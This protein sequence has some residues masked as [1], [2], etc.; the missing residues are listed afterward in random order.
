MKKKI[1]DLLRGDIFIIC[2]FDADVSARNESERKKLEQL[3]N[4]Y[5]KN[6]NLLFCSSLPSIEYWFL[7]HYLNTNQH[8]YDAKAVETALK[9]YISDYEKTAQ[10]LEKKRW[11]NDLCAENKFESAVKRAKRFEQGN[12]SYTNIY[13]A[14]DVLCKDLKIP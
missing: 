5:R 1:E 13:E 2:V 12:G 10:F 7:L 11:V 3:Q 6:K 9:Q 14:F 8:F 4:K